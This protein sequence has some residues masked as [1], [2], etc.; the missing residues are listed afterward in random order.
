MRYCFHY[1]LDEDANRY[2]SL[3]IRY[4]GDRNPN[5]VY[6]YK[7][8]RCGLPLHSID[9]MNLNK[10]INDMNRERNGDDMNFPFLNVTDIHDMLA[11]VPYAYDEDSKYRDN[12]L[13]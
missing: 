10:K 12:Q 7:C 6:K 11:P 13:R 3:A 9:I 2:V 1:Q 4:F 8:K 5:R